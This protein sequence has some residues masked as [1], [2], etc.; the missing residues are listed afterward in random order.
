MEKESTQPP[1]N[2]AAASTPIQNTL[3]DLQD[4]LAN[5]DKIPNDSVCELDQVKK[6]T[7]DLIKVISDQIKALDL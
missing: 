5:W 7:C 6:K 1:E 2:V 3:K 4:A